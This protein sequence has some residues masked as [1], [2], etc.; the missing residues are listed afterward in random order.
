MKWLQLPTSLRVVSEMPIRAKQQK[1]SKAPK[2]KF[3]EA[4]FQKQINKLA[5]L[6]ISNLYGVCVK[7]MQCKS[8]AM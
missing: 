6:P 2:P 3:L 5:F 4:F 1:I 7:A 8:N